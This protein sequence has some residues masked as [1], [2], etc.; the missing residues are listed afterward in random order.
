M[1]KHTRGPWVWADGYEGL[2]GLGPE[3]E[4]LHYADYEGMWIAEW[5]ER[6]VANA[7]LIAAAPDLLAALQG[8]LKAWVDLINS[9]DAGNWD[10]ETDAHVIAARAAIA[11]ATGEA[12]A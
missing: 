5:S 4:V 2:F 7:L 8:S 9:G 12:T 11:K 10:P 3:N 1:V 6:G